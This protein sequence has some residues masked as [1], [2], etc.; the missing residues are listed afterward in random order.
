MNPKKYLFICMLFLPLLLGLNTAANPVQLKKVAFRPGKDYALLFAVENYSNGWSPLRYPIDEAEAIA[1]DL[2]SLYGFQVELIRNPSKKQIQEKLLEYGRRKENYVEDAQ[3]F[4]FFSGHGSFAEETKEGFIIPADGKEN[5]PF[6]D[7][8]YAHDRLKRAVDA[9]PCK[10]IL[11]AIDACYSGTIDDRIANKGDPPNWKLPGGPDLANAKNQ[12]FIAENLM[13]KTRMYITSGGKEQTP[14]RSAFAE[15]ILDAL[16]S[17]SSQNP[18]LNFDDLLGFLKKAKPLPRYGEFGNVE[19][20]SKNFLFIRQPNETA[21]KDEDGI[22]DTRDECPTLYAKTPSGC[23]DADGDGIPDNKDNCKYES[24]L[25]K[26]NGC[27]VPTADTD[28]DGVPDAGDACPTEKG[29]PRFSGCPDKD[30]DGVPDNADNCPNQAGPSSNSGCPPP[31][32]RDR[33]GVP[34]SSDMCPDTYGS[35]T[36]NGCPTPSLILNE[37]VLIKGGTFQMGDIFDDKEEINET[38]HSVTV[39]DFLLAKN[40]LTFEEFDAFCKATN[41]SLPADEG[42]GRGKRPVINIDWYDAVEYCNWRSGQEKLALAYAIEKTTQDVNNTN[43]ND[44]KKWKVTYIRNANGYRLPTESEWEYAARQQGQ[45]VR[46]GNGKDQATSKEINFD[47]SRDYRRPYSVAGENRKK[48]L[49]VGSLSANKLGLFDMSGNVAEWCWDWYGDYPKSP[50]A[51]PL[52]AVKS[53]DRVFRGGSWYVDPA[54]VRVA[55]RNHDAPVY[56]LYNLGF[57]LA[58]QR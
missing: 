10:H 37:M 30:S 25:A 2:Q 20:G 16:R 13:Y 6:Q 5:D 42:W 19:P 14:D 38:V 3:L 41:R 56:R 53:S 17:T 9:I 35:T 45:R 54:L 11:L 48:T 22:P 12:N 29:L 46:F 44:K 34:D 50:I 57:R 18:I 28:G 7:S 1:R 8:Y 39:S 31:I 51:N 4:V 58:K 47:A 26:N 55:V 27:P 33:D 49:P 36:N 23:P 52:G 21:D 15:K 24:G 32:D 40:E 43:S